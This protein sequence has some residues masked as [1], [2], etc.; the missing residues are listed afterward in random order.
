MTVNQVLEHYGGVAETARALGITYQAVQQWVDK[1]AV[2]VGRQWEIQ[3]KS[4]GALTA[5]QPQSA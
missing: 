2:P 4:Q 5:D 1:N 3:A